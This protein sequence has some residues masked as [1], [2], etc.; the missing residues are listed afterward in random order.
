MRLSLISQ[1]I[2][3][4]RTNLLYFITQ[5]TNLLI[6]QRDKMLLL[7]LPNATLPNAP[8]IFD[9]LLLRLRSIS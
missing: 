9:L 4:Q 7:L 3:S 8:S 6:A 1:S 5:R 2:T